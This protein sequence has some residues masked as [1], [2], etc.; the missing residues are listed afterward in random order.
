MEG[1]AV[2]KEQSQLQVRAIDGSLAFAAD[3]AREPTMGMWT[4]DG[5]T[6]E[7]RDSGGI[8]SWTPSTGQSHAV[9]NGLRWF[10]PWSSRDGKLIAFDSG[11]ESP[12]VVVRLLTVATA[13]YDT[14]SAAGRA[15]P[16]FAGPH[17]IWAQQVRACKICLTPAEPIPHVVA[18]D[19]RNG[20]ESVLAI[21]GLLDVDVYYA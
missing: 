19:T 11:W 21:Q 6:L 15:F 9:R 13:K 17:T 7:Y 18:I 12:S 14:V 8:R 2:P 1:Q 10:D 5:K 3:M 16:V 20:K 4:P